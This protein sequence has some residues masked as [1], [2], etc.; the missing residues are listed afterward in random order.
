VDSLHLKFLD[1]VDHRLD[2]L[3]R[4]LIESHDAVAIVDAIQQ[5]AVLH[6]AGAVG[7]E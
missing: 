3:G 5:V 2:D 6:A 4:A 1:G 7:Y